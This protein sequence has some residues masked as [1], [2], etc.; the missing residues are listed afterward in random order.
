MSELSAG[1]MNKSKINPGLGSTVVLQSWQVRC[2][3]GRCW[4]L[5]TF[6]LSESLLQIRTYC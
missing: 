2:V 3:T 4:S 6:S 5:S 1:L